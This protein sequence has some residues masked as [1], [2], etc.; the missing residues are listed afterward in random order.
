MA[1]T[2]EGRPSLKVEPIMRN[3]DVRQEIT[4]PSCHTHFVVLQSQP[5][6]YCVNCKAKLY[7]A[8][9]S[10]GEDESV[11]QTTGISAITEPITIISE[12]LPDKGEIKFAIG[13]YQVIGSV[14][15]GGMG[16]VFLAYD[17][18]CG[19]RI[20]LK[21]IRPDLIGQKHLHSRFMKEARIT[22][23]LT[24]PAIIPIYAI[25]S[26]EGLAYYTMPFVEGK[27]LRQILMNARKQE[28]KGGKPD[29]L[30]SIP[31]LVRIF[32]SVC[33]AVAYAH[34]KG[35]VHRDLKPNNII[36][37]RYGETLILDWG[38]AKLITQ[39]PDENESDVELE[40][41]EDKETSQEI[42]KRGKVV[43]TVAYLAPERALGNPATFQSDVY[44]LGVILYQ[45]LTLHH[46]FHRASLQEFRQNMSREV[47]LD[48]AEVAPYRDVPPV[49][50]RMVFKS[51]SP[52]I[53][54]RYHTVDELIHD[55]ESYLEGRSEWF[56]MTELDI[57]RKSDW[58]F[59]ENV[60]IAEH[61][62]IT[63]GTDVSDWVILMISKASFSGNTKLEARVRIG[64]KGHGVGFLLS[65]PE[66]EERSHPNSG[67]CLW[68]ASDLS[69]NTKL[70]RA[71]VEVMHA[72]EIFLH[73]H[74]WYQVRI[75]KIENNI[76]FYL[77]D[78]LQFSYI[79]HLPLR[80]THVGLLLRDMDCS[81]KDCTISVGSQNIT[82]NCLAVPDAFLAHKDY[83]TALSEYRRIGYAFPGT[84]EAREALFRAGITLL[85]SAR[86]CTDAG[87]RAQKCEEA[88][89]EFGKLRSTPGAP[90]EYLGKALVYQALGDYKEEVKCFELAHRR[91]PSHPL[92]PV[93]Q[94]QLIYRMH[95]SSHHDR[96]ATYHFV[97]LAS[98]HL[99]VSSAGYNVKR[100]FSS[101]KKNWEP[102][103]FIVEE[104]LT[105][106]LHNSTFAIVIAFWLAKP[107]VLVE[108]IDELVRKEL[109]HFP[110]IDN[111]LFALVEL[112]AYG[113]A[114]RKISEQLRGKEIG[115][116][117]FTILSH[118]EPI[119]SFQD[120]L[121]TKLP[122]YIAKQELRVLLHIME[123]A[124]R[125][126]KTD[127]VY[128][129]VQ[130]LKKHTLS[131]LSQLRI[132]CCVIWAY[133]WDK[134]WA[135]AEELLHRYTLE[136]LT[137]ET[138]LLH[139][140]YGCWLYVTEGKD[141]AAIHFA[142]V[143]EVSYPRSW[144]LFGQFFNR[145]SEEQH[146][147]LQKAFL[148]EKRQLY[149]Q[150]ALFYHCT[151]E[152]IAKEY[153]QL[154]KQQYLHVNG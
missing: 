41:E 47:L 46:P 74:M 54:E 43:G 144:T 71:T 72:P 141:I 132:D 42:T 111:A 103:N 19:R 133:L 131:P 142:S 105:E 50:S 31:A 80:G 91:Y 15:K 106:T 138:T 87:L 104:D 21:R 20:A 36:V 145:T 139:F 123:E 73:R 94:E 98:R 70:L 51:L 68:I 82:V 126:E 143:L 140:L 39:I 49:L 97:L 112:G 81:I 37:G 110:V 9:K 102:L 129:M 121:F 4:C 12:H 23:Q 109:P 115:L 40:T 56:R 61:M 7:P 6:Q 28:K 151:G 134:N 119:E 33:Q 27:T 99:P 78:V 93:L 53:E 38:L 136:Q 124:I 58:E 60:L 118:Q 148:W 30:T 13:P 32:L 1:K 16:E 147:W 69:R 64:E 113:L 114:Q 10:I 2:Q 24:H 130:R 79:S 135:A 57:N 34:S 62:A 14:G 120:A 75:E 8:A 85:E 77:N 35:V 26:E 22:S 127:I 17:T 11:Q 55:V 150:L 125:Q 122:A 95:D 149:R 117:N 152:K 89:E 90:L 86:I 108:I 25:Q 18:T 137:Q 59:Q 29:N 153:L 44:S 96:Q 52:S 100:L 116:L 84:A 76:Y 65:I 63:R 146:I 5:I 83:G 3:K 67:Y 128:Q 92:L 45:I 107:Y 88:L 66:L 101:L 48:P 154:E